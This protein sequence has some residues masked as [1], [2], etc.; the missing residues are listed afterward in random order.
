MTFQLS[1]DINYGRKLSIDPIFINIHIK[2]NLS[3]IVS[4][5]IDNF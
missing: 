4:K 3:M 5:C 1:S 2:K